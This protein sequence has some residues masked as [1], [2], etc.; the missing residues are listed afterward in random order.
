MGP[1][2]DDGTEPRPLLMGARVEMT[3]RELDQMHYPEDI[4]RHVH[5]KLFDILTDGM[6]RQHATQIE[7]DSVDAGFERIG[8]R[9]ELLVM[10]K[11][12]WRHITEEVFRLQEENRR[13]KQL[14]P[15]P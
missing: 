15:P 9:L 14:Q 11:S 1:R 5:R 3:A 6:I 13:L 4:K 7:R 8:Y 10:T 12:E 2:L